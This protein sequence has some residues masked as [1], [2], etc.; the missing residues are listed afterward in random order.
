MLV[1]FPN[2]L[3]HTDQSDYPEKTRQQLFFL[4]AINAKIISKT[5]QTRGYFNFSF[6]FRKQS[7]YAT[8]SDF[9]KFIKTIRSLDL[10][11]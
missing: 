10:I 4:K 7:N 3:L 1:Q 11:M 8:N 9:L 2:V 5:N 6:F